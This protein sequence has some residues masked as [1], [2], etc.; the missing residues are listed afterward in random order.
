MATDN[1][2]I[3]QMLFLIL[4]LGCYNIILGRIWLIEYYVLVDYTGKW[5]I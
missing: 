4:D 3:R 1:H 2:I 5:L